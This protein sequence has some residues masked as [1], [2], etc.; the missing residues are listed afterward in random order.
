M[1]EGTLHTFELHD[2]DDPTGD[3]CDCGALKIMDTWRS[4]HGHL[5]GIAVLVGEGDE[6]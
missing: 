4:T 2:P 3:E 5:L 1:C 6:P